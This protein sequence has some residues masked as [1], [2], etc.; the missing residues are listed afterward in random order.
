MQKITESQ[1]LARVRGLREYMAEADPTATPGTP[2]PPQVAAPAA[3]AN[4][5]QGKDPA[6]AAA[7][8]KLSPMVQKKIGMADP[9]D[10]IIVGRMAK[11]ELGGLFGGGATDANPDGTAKAATIPVKANAAGDA[12]TAADLAQLKTL[13]AKLGASAGQAAKPVPAAPLTPQNDPAMKDFMGEGLNETMSRLLNTVRL[14]EA[15]APAPA[16]GGDDKAATIKQIQDIMARINSNNENP[17]PEIATA[18]ADAQKAID[19][20]SAAPAAP[21]APAATAVTAPAQAGK[22]LT[23]APQDG[24]VGQD[25]AK[26][27]ISRQN[28]LDQAFVDK[29]LGAGKYTAG[30]AESNL[31]LQ[32]L[33]KKNGGKLPQPPA[34]AAPQLPTATTPPAQFALPKGP[35]PFDPTDYTKLAKAP[36]EPAAP[37][38]MDPNKPGFD[39]KKASAAQIASQPPAAPAPVAAPTAVPKITPKALPKIPESTG[40]NEIDR[41]VSL[42][43]YK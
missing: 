4:P 15:D 12:A 27:G 39:F 37:V 6:K 28:R 23:A 26:M 16:A 17:S 29:A 43:N 34:A 22:A 31:A 11:G 8:A 18:L 30:S 41:L 19:T 25:L 36:P 10:N 7:W 33:A 13:I 3:S 5:W 24:V 20:A 1:L 9:T 38:V 21:A 14:L 40:Y 42:V 2:P 32:A 35:K